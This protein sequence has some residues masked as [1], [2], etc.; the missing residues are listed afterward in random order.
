MRHG[1]KRVSETISAE[2]GEDSC[3]S[4]GGLDFEPVTTLKAEE[5]DT[6]VIQL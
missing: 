3:H 2:F 6:G 4:P 5:T 1:Q